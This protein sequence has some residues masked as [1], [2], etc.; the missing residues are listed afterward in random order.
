ML[1]DHLYSRAI[2]MNILEDIQVEFSTDPSRFRSSQSRP[3]QSSGIVNQDPVNQDLVNQDPVNQDLVIHPNQVQEPEP[4]A[5]D[6]YGRPKKYAGLKFAYDSDQNNCVQVDPNDP[7]N[8]I[9]GPYYDTWDECVNANEDTSK[10]NLVITKTRCQQ[11]FAQHGITDKRTL[12]ATIRQ[13]IQQNHADLG[14]LLECKK[15]FDEYFGSIKRRR[16]T[17]RKRKK[18]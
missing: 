2:Q 5:D 6:D 4:E 7:N 9:Y 18:N 17:K 16:K 15:H 1:I 14:D 11:L 13:F 12:N 10:K 3:S 8:T